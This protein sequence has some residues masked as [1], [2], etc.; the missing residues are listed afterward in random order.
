VT[1]RRSYRRNEV[2]RKIHFFRILP[3]QEE[4]TIQHDSIVQA[5][6]EIG[7]LPWV[8]NQRYMDIGDGSSVCMWPDQS[9][10][11]IQI[12]MGTRRTSG[13]PDIEN[14]GNLIP[15]T[16]GQNDGLTEV[17][18]MIIFRNNILGSEFNFYGPRAQRLKYYLNEKTCLTNH[19]IKIQMLLQNDITQKLS[20][21][22]EIRMVQFRFKRTDA[23]LIEEL[24]NQGFGH[25]LKVTA[26]QLNTP[27]IELTLKNTKFSRVSLSHRLFD[28]IKRISRNP[29][30]KEIFEKFTIKGYNQETQQIEILDLLGDMLI[31]TKKVVRQSEKTRNIN[32]TSM[33]RAINDAYV[34]LSDQILT[35]AGLEQEQ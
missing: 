33:Y 30:S 27:V 25:S 21:F 2:E 5:V 35:A 3:V 14:R 32:S 23:Q 31:S 12:R 11:E 10:P 1:N 7:N 20:K 19:P 4:D 17:T 15:L 29:R 18:H 16:M 26:E 6:S 22:R 24:D 13:L 8:H 9:H 28:S 34:E